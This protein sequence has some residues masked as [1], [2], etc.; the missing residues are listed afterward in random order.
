M[1]PRQADSP[2]CAPPP[3]RPADE[4]AGP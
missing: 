2:S 3:R 1:L 4:R